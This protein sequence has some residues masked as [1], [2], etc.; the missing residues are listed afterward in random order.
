[1]RDGQGSK[2]ENHNITQIS[3][4]DTWSTLEFAQWSGLK[5]SDIILAVVKLRY[6]QIKFFLVHV[7]DGHTT[8]HPYT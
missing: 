1:M 2:V 8:N 5:F 3:E 4:N 6:V 7:M